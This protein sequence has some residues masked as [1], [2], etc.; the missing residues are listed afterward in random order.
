[1]LPLLQVH[2]LV[3]SKGMLISRFFSLEKWQRYEEQS[4]NKKRD[5]LKISGYHRRSHL[6]THSCMNY[7]HTSSCPPHAAVF[8]ISSQYFPNS[9]VENNQKTAVNFCNSWYKTPSI[10]PTISDEN[11]YIIYIFLYHFS[12][13]FN[14][15]PR[16]RNNP[17][18]FP[19][20]FHPKP[21]HFCLFLSTEV[22]T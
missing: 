1:M 17:F 5:Q 2:T 19:P 22:H 20:L 18:N 10:A 12:A 11:A 8:T 15:F 13:Q 14:H 21:N 9:S 16:C 7:K 4:V 3:K 6:T